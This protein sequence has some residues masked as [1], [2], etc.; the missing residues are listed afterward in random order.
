V[1]KFVRGLTLAL[2]ITVTALA[3]S[4]LPSAQAAQTASC[5]IPAATGEVDATPLVGAAIIQVEGEDDEAAAS[6]PAATPVVAAPDPIALLTQELTAVAESLAACLTEGDAETVTQLAGER[7]LGQ[8]FGGSVPLPKEEYI[9]IAGQLT[10]IPTRIVAVE[11]VVQAADDR[12]TALVS[13]VVG[14]QLLRAEWTFE[15]APGGE[16]DAGQ[17]P[18]RL[19]GE[20]Q[21]PAVPSLDAVPI[22][23]E[24]GDRSF[25]LS[26]TAVAGP[27]VVLRG[28]N[29]S[30]EDHEMLVLRL[31]PGYT[32]ADLLRATGP[33]LP[34]EVT[35]IGELPIPAGE[36]RDLVLVDLAP[37]DYTVVCLFTNEQGTPH[38]AQ[39]MEAVFT[40]G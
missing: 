19:D 5:E 4:R 8:L 37:G 25:T 35:F 7:Y 21:R 13:H 26:K 3:V 29:I 23:V 20:R 15:H 2:V 27:D 31:A 28:I 9:A 12:A 39:G 32:T 30:S 18:W 34:R 14:N 1:G 24:I 38:L 33:D 22:G 16:R 17:N 10:P 6:P 36:Q 40:V 11:D